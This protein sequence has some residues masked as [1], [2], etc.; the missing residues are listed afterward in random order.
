MHAVSRGEWFLKR[1]RERYSRRRNDDDAQGNEGGAM[2][3]MN[4]AAQAYQ[5]RAHARRARI[6]SAVQR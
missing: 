3:A 5:L 1:T 4:E 2:Q 6:R